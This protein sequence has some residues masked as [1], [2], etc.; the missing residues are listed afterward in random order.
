VSATLTTKVC[1]LYR[2]HDYGTRK[3]RQAP[4]YICRLAG[5]ALLHAAHG[6]LGGPDF[7]VAVGLR[8]GLRLRPSRACDQT[9]WHEAKA[10]LRRE[11]ACGTTR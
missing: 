2:E 11:G 7:T 3:S 4:P 9:T 8:G 5:V 10:I 6:S 1:L